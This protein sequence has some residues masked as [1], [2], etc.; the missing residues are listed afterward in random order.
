[1]ESISSLS[2]SRS[3]E[4]TAKVYYTLQAEKFDNGLEQDTEETFM[5]NFAR[6]GNTL[7]MIRACCVLVAILLAVSLGS[8]QQAAKVR[9]SGSSIQTMEIGAAEMASLPRLSLDVEDAHSGKPH[10]FSGV[11]LSDLLAKAGVP[12]G[13]KLRGKE[14][15]TYVLV[16][17]TDG[18]AVVF[19]V[20]EL[21]SALSG[22]QI[23]LA[24]T[25]DGKSLDANEG[26]FRVIAPEDKR[27]A[28]WVRMVNA[29]EVV[30]ALNPSGSLP[31]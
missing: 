16:R 14:L 23:I 9:I 4:G 8:A 11:K 28:R 6:P 24:D 10:H 7:M 27:P 20:A 17:A 18:Y 19:S 12:T 15:A 5:R 25:V 1:M 31:R 21:D 30:S 22:S 13:D 2:Q 3:G 26:P 29:I